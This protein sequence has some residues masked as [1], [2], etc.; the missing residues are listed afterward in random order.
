MGRTFSWISGQ[1]YGR[2]FVTL[3]ARGLICSVNARC[4][5]VPKADGGD[6]G[7]TQVKLT[8]S[9]WQ[10]SPRKSNSTPI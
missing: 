2:V 6:I 4:R 5:M 8:C 10:M 3:L 1:P 7:W 9:T